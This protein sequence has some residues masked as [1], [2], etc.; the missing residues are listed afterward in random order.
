MNRGVITEEVS[1]Q[2]LELLPELQKT[3][4]KQIMNE[5]RI[6]IERAVKKEINSQLNATI[7]EKIENIVDE[8]ISSLK[9]QITNDVKHSQLALIKSSNANIKAQVQKDL[10]E[11][12]NK[13]IAPKINNFINNMGMQMADHTE[14]ITR[15]RRNVNDGHT[16]AAKDAVRTMHAMGAGRRYT[17]AAAIEHTPPP[18]DPQ[19]IQFV[20]E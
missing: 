13:E 14:M 20:L 6:T 12:V 8:K 5:M 4:R 18:R 19:K 2:L 11:T 15:Y 1:N 7:D 17:G 3:I 9:Y 10:A 16:H